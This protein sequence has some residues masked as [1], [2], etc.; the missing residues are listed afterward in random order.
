MGRDVALR[1]AKTVSAK[2]M[3]VPFAVLTPRL[4]LEANRISTRVMNEPIIDLGDY[5]SGFPMN[6]KEYF[7][8]SEGIPG[9]RPWRCLGRTTTG[10]YFFFLAECEKSARPFAEGRAEFHLFPAWNYE[11][12]I[13]YA[14]DQVSYDLY[15]SE[16]VAI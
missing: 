2:S 7:W 12:L 9:E 15:M 11:N 13:H 6:V 10:V 5:P 14:M 16:T 3:K 8:T 1:R 4:G